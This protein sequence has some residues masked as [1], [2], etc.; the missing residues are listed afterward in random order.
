M[1]HATTILWS[2]NKDYLLLNIPLDTSQLLEIAQ[3]AHQLLH[4]LYNDDQQ[5][6]QKFLIFYFEILALLIYSNL[7]L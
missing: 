6:V 4:S 2:F 5:N 1:Q 7:W 3:K